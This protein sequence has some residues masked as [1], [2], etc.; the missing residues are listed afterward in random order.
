[1]SRLII[2]LVSSGAARHARRENDDPDNANEAFL[3]GFV[4]AR[5]LQLVRTERAS[6]QFFPYEIECDER[7]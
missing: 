5:A 7:R 1:M 6:K 4:D 2:A 3:V